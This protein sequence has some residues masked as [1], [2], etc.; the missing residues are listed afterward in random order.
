MVSVDNLFS[1]D[2]VLIYKNT[3]T[4]LYV[5]VESSD[6]NRLWY[7]EIYKSTSKKQIEKSNNGF[8]Q[9]PSYQLLMVETKS[10]FSKVRITNILVYDNQGSVIYSHKDEY[11]E[12]ISPVPDSRGEMYCDIAKDLSTEGVNEFKENMFFQNATPKEI[13][14]YVID[15]EVGVLQDKPDPDDIGIDY[16]VISDETFEVDSSVLENGEEYANEDGKILLYVPSISRN[17]TRIVS[18]YL[19]YDLVIA[20]DCPYPAD[21]AKR[22]ANYYKNSE[23]TEVIRDLVKDAKMG[24]KISVKHGDTGTAQSAIIIAIPQSVT[25][26]KK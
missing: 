21:I 18:N 25:S 9:L 7:K 3:D 17:G 12:F 20:S 1:A 23:D 16:N 26:K 6:F 10:N 15:N 24:F 22:I 2:W 4:E 19:I 13:I 14:E 11:G 8:S 5:N